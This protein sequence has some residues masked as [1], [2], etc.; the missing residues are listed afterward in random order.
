MIY[1]AHRGVSTEYPENTMPA[2]EA[3]CQQGY[4]IIELDPV[5]TADM[6]CVCFHDKTVNRTCR[7]SDGTRI[8]EELPVADMTYDELM[9]L[10]AGVYM[11]TE[12]LGT[13]V[14]LLQQAL[15]LA[16]EMNVRVKLDNKLQRFNAVQMEL[17]FSIIEQSG[18]NGEFTCSKVDVIEQVVKRFPDAVIH[19]DGPVD[20]NVL[21]TVR[22][23][24]RDNPLTVWLP[25]ESQLTS[26][27]KVPFADAAHCDLARQFGKLGLWILET[28]DQLR[29]AQTFG[30][31]II[32]TT[33]KLKP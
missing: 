6:K 24:L 7:H 12:F 13:R 28:E 5:F 27:A 31:D 29:Q 33:G 22:M 9:Q 14:P 1:Q 2:F 15:K 10:D 32:E 20:R 19:Y 11:G 8:E 25:L 17:F 30:A 16:K 26:W 4:G 21:E 3:A 18:A 23:C